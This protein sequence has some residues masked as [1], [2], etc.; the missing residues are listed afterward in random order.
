MHGI[1]EAR[2]AITIVN[3]L[4]TGIGAAVG[5]ELRARADVE[6]HPA[7][8]HGKWDVQVADEA[9]TPLVIASLAAA[10]N[11]FAPG[12]SG[13]GALTLR[14]EIPPARG[15]KSSSAVSSAVVLAV[16][17]AIDA[18]VES[19]DV[20]RLSATVSKSA[21]V[22]STGALDDALAG[23]RPGVVVTDNLRGELLK[24]YPLDPRLGV[25]LFVPPHPHLRSPQ[26]ASAFAAEAARGRGA[27]DAVLA[28]EWS[29]AMQANTELVE[30]VV[31]Y[32]YASV[33]AELRRRGAIACGVSGMGP[34]LAAVAPEERLPEVVAAFPHGP[35][36]RHTVS[37]S[38]AEPS[39]E[40]IPP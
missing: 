34:A 38:H 19:I 6:L 8:S 35:G 13:E 28:G 32:D 15:L 39:A 18:D 12:S 40:G 33:R 22:S 30:R 36:E 17:R 1:G 26:W 11:Q 24:S 31:G 14:S 27:V 3:A 4:P 21:G 10:L 5:I 29:A 23:L 16:A 2:A 37:F 9:R 25:A 20:A 7:G